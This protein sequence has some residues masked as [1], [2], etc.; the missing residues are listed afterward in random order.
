MQLLLITIGAR[1]ANID[2]C[3]NFTPYET[4]FL[5]YYTSVAIAFRNNVEEQK[6]VLLLQRLAD[7]TPLII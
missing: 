1:F 5:L 2:A 6:V 3:V 7:A 4:S